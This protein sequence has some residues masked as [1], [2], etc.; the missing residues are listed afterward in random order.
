MP[1]SD[2]YA[3]YRYESSHFV[4][5]QVTQEDTP[6]LLECYSDPAAVALM[7][8]DNCTGG[9]LCQTLEDVREHIRVWNEEY[10]NRMY[11]RPAIEDKA[12][13]QILGTME[14]FGGEP[15]VLRLDLRTDWER[16]QVLAEL[17]G[18]AVREFPRDFDMSGLVTKAVPEAAARREALEALGFS[19][20]G[21]FRGYGDYY[22]LDFGGAQSRGFRRELG[23]AYCGLACCLC[24]ENQGCPGCKQNGCAV[25][26][27]CVNYGCVKE[28]G[29]D[30]C[31]ECPEFPCGRGMHSSVRIQAFAKFAKEHGV[32]CLLDCLERNEKAGVVYHRP[33]GLT[34]DYDLPTEREILELIGHG[35]I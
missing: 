25:Y 30:G 8:D 29:V 17:L 27:Q 35:R 10:R 2:P 21:E 4:L 3:G 20:P 13:G 7:N 26:E 28:H 23:I 19:G 1:R 14:V 6:A 5:R 9:F 12:T 18:L 16:P 32:Q 33:G 24:S 31:W 15:G 22:R 34:G 11:I